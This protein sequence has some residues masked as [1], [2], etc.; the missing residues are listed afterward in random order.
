MVEPIYVQYYNSYC[1]LLETR[2]FFL[3]G[4][5]ECQKWYSEYFSKVGYPGFHIGIIQTLVMVPAAT[6][7]T[8][9]F[10]LSSGGTPLN[11]NNNFTIYHHRKSVRFGYTLENV[12]RYEFADFRIF[13]FDS[14]RSEECI[15]FR[16]MCVFFVF[17]SV[18]S[19]TSRNN[20]PISNYGGGFRYKSEYPR[21][22][23]KFSKKL[24]KTKKKMTEKREFLRK[25]SFRPN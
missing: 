6:Y 2:I 11:W 4:Y 8:C 1:C 17:V 12:C 10:Q 13:Y 5:K 9:K 7:F 16:M 23:I 22:I 25:T 15:D 3:M 18:Y 21:C 14:E 24:R 20:A 19:I